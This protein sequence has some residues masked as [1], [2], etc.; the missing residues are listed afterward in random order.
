MQAL[1]MVK[2]PSQAVKIMEEVLPTAGHKVDSSHYAIAMGGFLGT[3]EFWNVFKLHREFTQLNIGKAGDHDPLLLRARYLKDMEIF[4]RTGN[5]LEQLQRSMEMFLEVV[6]SHDPQAVSNTA[7]KGM[8][9]AP[10]DIAHPTSMYSFIIYVLAQNHNLETAK[11]LYDRYQI[12]VPAKHKD[13]NVKMISAMTLIR[14][15]EHDHDGVEECW[16]LALAAAK[17]HGK[18]LALRDKNGPINI[19]PSSRKTAKVL[20]KHQIDL[21]M[22]LTWYLKSLAWTGQVDKM[23]VTVNNHLQDGFALDM[24]NWNIYIEL[25]CQR[26]RPKLAFEVCEKYLISNWPGWSQI[27]RRQPVRNRLPIEIRAKRKHPRWY[28]PITRSL[29]FL[30]RSYLDIEAMAA[31]SRGY[32]FMLD[33]L[34]RLYP[35]TVHAIRTMERSSDEQEREIL[36]RY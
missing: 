27:R 33:D 16:K 15:Q 10:L 34:E 23:I 31:E 1:A 4:G 29:V 8:G 5:D 9:D 7:R 19:L 2:Q 18:P 17:E 3:R 36:G 20:Y 6:N 25:L 13:S 30:A 24:R 26:S 28:R 32:Q 14:F 11:Q 12:A 21:A 22:T 35:K